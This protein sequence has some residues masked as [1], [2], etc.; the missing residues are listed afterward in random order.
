M[1][2]THKTD[3][4][5]VRMIRG[6]IHAYPVHN[7]EDGICDLPTIEE[8]GRSWYRKNCYWEFDS[9]GR[10]VCGCSMCQGKT[11]NGDRDPRTQRKHFNQID[12]EEEFDEVPKHKSKKKKGCKR[13]KWGSHEESKDFRYEAKWCRFTYCIHC[14]KKM[15]VQ[16]KRWNSEEWEN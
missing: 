14:G 16:Y 5:W 7:H 2:R 9:E 13:N 11:W 10:G 4:L 8:Q 3:P 6:T 15:T 12:W 1:S